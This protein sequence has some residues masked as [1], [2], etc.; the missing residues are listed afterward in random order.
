MGSEGERQ[1]VCGTQ[2]AAQH[3]KTIA[4]YCT[5]LHGMAWQCPSH[6]VMSCHVMSCPATRLCHPVSFEQPLSGDFLPS[7]HEGL[8]TCGR[9][10]HLEVEEEENG[11][12][13]E[14]E[15][16]GE[17]GTGEQSEGQA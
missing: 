15:R 14:G 3:G 1:G 9:A 16:G 5:S 8:R 17:G 2:N 12:E 11:E 10:T 7:Q 13:E 4:L 6:R